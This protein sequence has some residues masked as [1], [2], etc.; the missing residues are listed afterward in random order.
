MQIQQRYPMQNLQ[1]RASDRYGLMRFLPPRRRLYGAIIGGLVAGLVLAVWLLIGEVTSGLPS[2]LTEMERQIAVWFGA[3]PHPANA[4]AS[5]AE[6]YYGI[7]GHL[8]LSALAGA[9]Y[10]IGWRRDK[11]VILNGLVFGMAFYAVAHAVVGPI[12]GLTPPIWGVPLSLFLLGCV[13]NGFFG[14]VTAFFAHQFEI[15]GLDQLD[16]N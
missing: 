14:L 1:F 10:A 12:T 6:E 16:G 5:T 4:V 7:F 15:G 13:I 2:Q 3:A 9:G 11:S 8:L